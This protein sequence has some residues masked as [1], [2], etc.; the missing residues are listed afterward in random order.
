MHRRADASG[1]NRL[2]PTP[3]TCRTALLA[4]ALGFR[5]GQAWIV[6]AR[7]RRG[8]RMARELWVAITQAESG[9]GLA[10][11]SDRPSSAP[12]RFRPT[13]GNWRA[14]PTGPHRYSSLS[15]PRVPVP[16]DVTITRYRTARLR[17][18]SARVFPGCFVDQGGE[19]I[20]TLSP[21]KSVHSGNPSPSC[22]TVHCGSRNAFRVFLPTFHTLPAPIP[23][24]M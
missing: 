21:K 10:P 11:E 9:P 1:L 2:N 4:C 20:V 8:R 19:P 7:K 16:R 3:Q 12:P 17:R 23:S 22:A 13:R 18:S 24:G 6:S 14:C 15:V 5:E